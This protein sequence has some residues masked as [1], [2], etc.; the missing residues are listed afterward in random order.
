MARFSRFPKEVERYL[1]HRVVFLGTPIDEYI[2]QLV[3]AQILYLS[4]ED[5]RK[6]IYL[7]VNSPGGYVANSLAIFDLIRT[8]K[9]PIHTHCV[10]QAHGMAAL[11]VAAGAKGYRTSSEDGWFQMVPLRGPNSRDAK[12]QINLEVLENQVADQ[13]ALL[14]GTELP[15]ILEDMAQERIL[16]GKDA[17]GYGLVDAIRSDLPGLSASSG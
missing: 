9:I 6:P 5:A 16:R 4:M 13:F 12:A 10:K 14:T 3:M 7:L 17:V 2:A 8:S 11:L 1:K 15:H